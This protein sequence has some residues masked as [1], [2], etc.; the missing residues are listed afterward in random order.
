MC[1]SHQSQ[2]VICKKVWRVSG[3]IVIS[4]YGLRLQSAFTAAWI[5]VWG[6]DRCL[7]IIQI[8]VDR[9]VGVVE[10]WST[11]SGKTQIQS[12]N[13]PGSF[14]AKN[15]EIL[16]SQGVHERQPQNYYI[17]RNRYT[18]GIGTWAK[19]YWTALSELWSSLEYQGAH[20][21]HFRICNRSLVI[22]S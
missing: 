19:Q 13:L 2:D 14:S 17:L 4:E 3:W 8:H 1:P 22:L 12:V 7:V 16:I 9:L 18:S 10:Y 21:D 15:V 11:S 20:S 6:K 5:S